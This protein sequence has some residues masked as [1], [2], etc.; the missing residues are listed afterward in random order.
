MEPEWRLRRWVVPLPP[1]TE[2]WGWTEGSQLA[3]DVSG[4]SFMSHEHR[5][6][7]EAVLGQCGV[8]LRMA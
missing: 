7:R 3:G 6:R 2:M 4:T 1:G 5:N 8:T